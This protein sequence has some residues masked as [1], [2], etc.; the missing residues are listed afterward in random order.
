MRNSNVHYQMSLLAK[1]VADFA[2]LTGVFQ[3]YDIDRDGT[4]S[5]DE[6]VRVMES[7]YKMIGKGTEEAATEASKERRK[8]IVYVRCELQ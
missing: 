4:I 2:D 5:H 8:A 3:L 1:I 7:I 6:M